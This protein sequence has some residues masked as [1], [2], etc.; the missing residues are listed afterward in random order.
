MNRF[1]RILKRLKLIWGMNRH[2]GPDSW[3]RF[4]GPDSRVQEWT[5]Q[6]QPACRDGCGAGRLALISFPENWFSIYWPRRGDL[7]G[8]QQQ[9][10]PL[11][12]NVGPAHIPGNRSFL[13][14]Q[15]KQT[16]PENADFGVKKGNIET[17]NTFK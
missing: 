8:D 11:G 7:F 17:E 1:S 13:P 6:K 9:A 16:P 4:K 12:L 3:F 10:A 2:E 14:L 15:W 5:V